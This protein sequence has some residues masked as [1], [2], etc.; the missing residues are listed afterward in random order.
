MHSHQPAEQGDYR[1]RYVAFLDLLGFKALVQ[2]AESDM[3]ERERLLQILRLLRDTLCADPKL[4]LRFTHFSDCIVLSIDRSAA[5]LWEAFQSINLLTFNLLQFDCFIRGGLVVGGAYH[6]D[7]FVYGTAVNEAHL[8][9]SEC[10]E[11]PMTLVSQE[12]VDDAAGYG[13]SF[14]EW[15]SED[16]PSRH[17]IHYLRQY[18]EYRPQPAFPGMMIMDEPAKRIIDFICHR[19]NTDTGRVL[20][21]AQWFR[22]YWNRTVA[23]HGIFG[24]IESGVTKR[25]TS[26][27]ATIGVRRIVGGGKET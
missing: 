4:G 17:F 13:T 12:V 18:A 2:R 8:L 16:S 26:R 25:Y 15:F 24:S 22:A 23:V 5:G 11:H 10:A 9:E 7:Q 14:L 1:E 3:V 6:S 21:K 20:A 19:L 27:G